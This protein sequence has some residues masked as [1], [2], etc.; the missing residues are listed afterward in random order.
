MD[1]FAEVF[2]PGGAIA[3]LSGLSFAFY[4]YVWKPQQ[5]RMD[6]WNERSETKLEE[7]VGELEKKV[8]ELESEVEQCHRDR[9]SEMEDNAKMRLALIRADI[10]IPD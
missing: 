8:H 9:R 4:R 1:P 5:D 7:R 6:A 10:P 2:A 3:I